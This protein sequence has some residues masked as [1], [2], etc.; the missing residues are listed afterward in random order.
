[1]RVI[2][3][4]FDFPG[5]LSGPN[6]WLIRTVPTFEK[7][8][9]EC[10]VIFLAWQPD[11]CPNLRAALAAGIHCIIIDQTQYSS[12]ERQVRRILSICEKNRPD[13]FVANIIISAL[14]AGRWLRKAGIPTVGVIRADNDFYAG[15]VDEFV[16]GRP[17]FRLKGLVCVSE[18][19]EQE[20]RR[21]HPADIIVTRIPSGTQVPELVASPPGYTLRLVYLGRLQQ[22]QKRICDVAR[23][24]CRAVR[25]LPG[26]E[27]DIFGHGPD[28][29]AVERILASEGAG[30]PVRLCGRID[31]E[32][33]LKTLASR[34]ALVL[35]SDYEGTPVAVMEAMA[36]GVVPICFWSRSGIPELVE[37]GVTGLI[38]RDREADFVRAV[39][40]L[41]DSSVYWA[42]LSRAARL[43]I[44]QRY[45]QQVVT[46][47]WIEFLSKLSSLADAPQSIHIPEHLHLPPV[48]PSLAAWDQR[49][50]SL[51][52]RIFRAGKRW[53]RVKVRRVIKPKWLKG[54]YFCFRHSLRLP[55]VR[56]REILHRL[57][58]LRARGDNGMNSFRF[59]WGDFQYVDPG[60]L[61]SQF[62]EIF[63]QRQYAFRTT[64][65]K[66][67]I[68]DCG[69]N[70][71][72]S[73]V[74]FKLNYPGCDL[75]VY[76]PDPDL[77]HAI[78]KNLSQAGLLGYHVHSKA[79]WIS[80]GVV[81]FRMTGDDKGRV[82]TG[83]FTEVGS[84]DLSEQLP[85]TVDLLKMDIEGAEYQVL[86]RLCETGAIRRVQCLVC[87]FHV[88]REKTSA[89]LKTLSNLTAN[90]FE[91]ATTAAAVPWIG[92][93]ATEA[94]FEAV[95]RDQV[96]ME[97]F[98]WRE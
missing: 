15:M 8:G 22:E 69:G 75:T 2:F 96:L 97:V 43:R 44:E 51:P 31:P 87:E 6:S 62:E 5:S 27:A 45:S 13:I 42:R 77:A 83:G 76:E 80:N 16:F 18:L 46:A 34:H 86:D 70:V 3:C 23:A 98:A 84:V 91:I 49:E 58:R 74:W 29:P 67:V 60:Q 89:L 37:D 47:Q 9:I 56:D 66:P 35:L 28:Q 1:M 14:F 95:R 48:R 19:L 63:I 79:V 81:K 32:D 55:P 17:E 26:V 39:R 20:V 61:R 21:R 7:A 10:E 85:S 92:L 50:A 73:A 88:W 78:E 57:S 36:A 52:R 40:E 41:R 82:A 94:P 54:F 65:S 59:P 53:T 30:L 33:V 72:L 38:V 12:T 11:D 24:M 93:A 64:N 71:G 90:G 4:T 25:E 68:I